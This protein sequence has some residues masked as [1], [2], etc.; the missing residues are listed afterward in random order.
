MADGDIVHDR[1]SR[2]YQ[3]PYKWLCQGKADNNE[4]ARVLMSAILRDIQKKGAAPMILAKQIGESLKQ[5]FDNGCRDWGSVGKELDRLAQQASC[6]HYLRELVLRAGKNILHN[7]RYG[8]AIETSKLVELTVRQ[9]IHEIY[10]SNFEQCIPLTS[11][12]YNGVDNDTVIKRVQAVGLEILPTFSKWA[13]QVNTDE[14]VANLRLPRRQKVKE[15]DLG[16][17]LL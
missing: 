8:S 14:D 13:K 16:E 6:S 12:H 17:N 4:C 9:Y 10:K 7:I 2:L 5:S 3:K 1:L 15:I 11:N